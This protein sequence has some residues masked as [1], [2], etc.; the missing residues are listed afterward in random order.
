MRYLTSLC[1][2]VPHLQHSKA[3]AFELIAAQRLSLHKRLIHA[4][5][6]S[7]FGDSHPSAFPPRCLCSPRPS[8]GP[9]VPPVHP[10]HLG[11]CLL[12]GKHLSSYPSP[13]DQH[14]APPPQ[15]KPTPFLAPPASTAATLLPSALLPL[16]ETWAL[17]LCTCFTPPGHPRP[18]RTPAPAHFTPAVSSVNSRPI[19]SRGNN[20]R[21]TLAPD[22]WW[23][24]PALGLMRSRPRSRG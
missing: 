11:T 4:G 16:D 1:P 7:P 21:Q 17:S 24:R 5:P 14:G 8:L 19:C 3:T 2:G 12:S 6:L 10:L 9:K 18:R 13:A 23:C 20:F 22:P 15:M